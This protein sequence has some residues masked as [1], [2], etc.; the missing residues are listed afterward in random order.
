MEWFTAKELGREAAQLD[1]VARFD[2]DELGVLDLMLG[3]LASM[4]PSVIFVP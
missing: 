3:E 1:L 4:R 2:L